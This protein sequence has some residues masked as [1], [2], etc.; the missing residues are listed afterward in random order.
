MV[1]RL[2]TQKKPSFFKENVAKFEEIIRSGPRRRKST[3]TEVDPTM[4]SYDVLLNLAMIDVEEDHYTFVQSLVWMLDACG[5]LREI[6]ADP[7]NESE[8]HV[9][10]NTFRIQGIANRFTSL[11]WQ[12]KLDT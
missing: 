1:L 2:V 9:T 8:V 10:W 12:T 11:C 5:Y 3:Y 7:N 6:A 4:E